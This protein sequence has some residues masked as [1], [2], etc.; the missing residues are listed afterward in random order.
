MPLTRQ[1]STR[2]IIAALFIPAMLAG[3]ALP[4]AAAPEPVAQATATKPD[5]A[6]N[7]WADRFAEDWVR[8]SPQSATSTQYFSGAEQARLDRALHHGACG[9]DGNAVDRQRCLGACQAR[10]QQ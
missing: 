1:R 6:F 2:A 8:L 9:G 7:V 10:C 5:A 3:V 4:V